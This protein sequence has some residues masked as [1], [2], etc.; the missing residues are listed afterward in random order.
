LDVLCALTGGGPTRK[1]PVTMVA[2][3][4]LTALPAMLWQGHMRLEI[5][6]DHSRQLGW[7]SEFFILAARLGGSRN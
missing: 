4:I 7:H 1:M 5:M 3:V 6:E 2:A